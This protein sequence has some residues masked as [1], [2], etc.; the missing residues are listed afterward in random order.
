MPKNDNSI[1]FV[2]AGMVPFKNIFIKNNKIQKNL[3]ITCQKCMRAGG[4]HNDLKNVGKSSMHHTFFEMLGNFTFKESFKKRMCTIVWN[5]LIKTLKIDKENLNIT[6]FSGNKKISKDYKTREIWKNIGISDSKIKEK[7][8]DE[9]FWTMGKTGPC[10]PSTEIYYNN[11][12][13][14]LRAEIWN[15]V[16]IEYNINSNL[17]IERLKYPSIDTGAGLERLSF[18]VNN[19]KNNYNTDLFKLI[20]YTIEKKTNKKYKSTNSPSDI[21]IRIIADHARSISFLISEGIIPSNTNQGYILRKI[22]RRSLRYNIKLHPNTIIYTVCQSVLLFFKQLYPELNSGKY[23]INK[24]I[25]FE[26]NL[27]QK[28]QASNHQILEQILKNKKTLK[29]NFIYKLYQTYGIRTNTVIQF[30]R[31]KNIKI[32]W[33]NFQKSKMKHK[34]ISKKYQN[35]K[36]KSFF[37]TNIEIYKKTYFPRNKLTINSK[38]IAIIQNNKKVN[39]PKKNKIIFLIL[40]KSIFYGESGGQIGDNGYIQKKTNHG[41]I[42]DTKR[43]NQ[44]HI[45]KFKLIRGIFKNLD[46]I[47][48]ILDY[49]KRNEIKKHHSAIHLLGVAL[50]VTIG[51]H[52][53]QKGSFVSNKKFRFDYSDFSNLTN[54]N[55]LKIENL[56]NYWIIDNSIKKTYEMPFLSARKKNAILIYGKKY[57][58][59]VRVVEFKKI[60]MEICNGTH[61]DST[62]DIGLLKI[63]STS[64][65]SSGIKRIEG[66]ASISAISL[67][68]NQ[69]Y[70]INKIKN[71]TKSTNKNILFNIKKIIDK[72]KK[73]KKEIKKIKLIERKKIIKNICNNIEYYKKF[74]LIIQELNNIKNERELKLLIK[75][76]KNCIKRIIIILITTFFDKKSIFVISVDQEIL[77][78]K[79]LNRIKANKIAEKISKKFSGSFGGNQRIAQSNSTKPIKKN[80][81]IKSLKNLILDQNNIK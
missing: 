11:L 54:K 13:L 3:I 49:K 63:T 73:I 65:I 42:I 80:K 52:I 25:L 33:E 10:G 55:I 51:K 64:S 16:F 38:I 35:L 50:R 26:K 31:K 47:K 27:F 57:N 46:N 7:G 67:F 17:K 39:I 74:N 59:N 1:L 8:E 30:C 23:L 43:I 78:D 70:L 15:I 76:I 32:S 66:V 40:D 79:T 41:I 61:V 4:K 60:S 36:L 81:I 2:N 29:G 44:I 58:T 20:I 45:H 12:I 37:L 56:I 18:I 28:T 21:A 71:L 62:I 72:N 14:K 24:I 5:F 53:I 6:I 48:C 34:K 9:N 77:N 19:E 68:Q 69:S 75:E 22:I